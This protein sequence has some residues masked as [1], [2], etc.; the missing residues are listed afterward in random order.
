[1][2]KVDCR[3]EKINSERHYVITVL[4]LKHKKTMYNIDNSGIKSLKGLTTQRRES[5]T[6]KETTLLIFFSVRK[7]LK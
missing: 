5:Q 2:M 7:S 3:K 4:S 6:N 1:M